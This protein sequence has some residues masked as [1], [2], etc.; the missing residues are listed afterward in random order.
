[1]TITAYANAYSTAASRYDEIESKPLGATTPEEEAEA[2]TLYEEMVSLEHL[3][4]NARP[5]TPSEATLQLAIAKSCLRRLVDDCSEEGVCEPV[6]DQATAEACLRAL[7]SSVIT[8]ATN[9]AE[10][11]DYALL[12]RFLNPSERS[13]TEAPH[14]VAA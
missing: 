10:Y 3:I 13:A 9:G 1:M 14:T 6:F 11:P 8:L 5:S 12:S 7:S 2:T 4:L